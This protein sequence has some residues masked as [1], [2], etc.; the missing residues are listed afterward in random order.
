MTN[1]LPRFATRSPVFSTAAMLAVSLLFAGCASQ[2]PAAAPPPVS[3]GAA[4]G[5]TAVGADATLQ[6]C[7]VPVGTVRLQDGNA[8]VATAGN[9]QASSPAVRDMLLV[10]RKLKDFNPRGGNQ[11]Q[12]FSIESSRLL[13]QQ[14][15]C[16]VIVDRGEAAAA[17]RAEKVDARNSGEVRDGSNMGKGQEVAADFVLRSMVLSMEEKSSGF[18]AGGL[19]PFASVIGVST[20]TKTKIANVQLVLSDVR[21]SLQLAAAQ[22]TG[23]TANTGLAVG[24]MGRAG[25]ALGGAGYKSEEKSPEA[26]VLLQAFADAYNKMVPAMRNYK[27]QTVRGGL[28]TGGTLGVQGARPDAAA[29]PAR[30]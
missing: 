20:G 10:M 22:G 26:T 30:P 8:P 6:T 11:S 9:E 5:G 1:I 19:I 7:T 3:T 13:I 2:Q 23:S 15:N 12:G 4:G 18:N 27:A 14:S 28:G 24:V 16:L 21:A 29:T 17:A 25:A